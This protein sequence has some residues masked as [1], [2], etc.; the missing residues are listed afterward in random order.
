VLSLW[1]GA[2]V[3]F[4]LNGIKSGN[5]SRGHRFMSPGAF[6]VKDFKSYASQAEPNF[7]IGDGA[8]RRGA[9]R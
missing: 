5:L 7:V 6:L 8:R 4:E 9:R 1:G 3:E 2:V